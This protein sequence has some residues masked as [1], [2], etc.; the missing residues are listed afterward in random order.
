MYGCFI[1]PKRDTQV[2]YSNFLKL[3]SLFTAFT[4]TS[5]N[6]KNILVAYIAFYAIT[7]NLVAL[8]ILT[9]GFDQDKKN[10]GVNLEENLLW[11]GLSENF[12]LPLFPLTLILE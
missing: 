8:D 2:V 4:E 1:F 9:L 12:F 5:E 3:H 7:H 6:K 10:I 11:L